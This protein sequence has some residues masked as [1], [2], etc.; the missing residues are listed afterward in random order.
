MSET[1][2]I[3]VIGGGIIGS[4][5]AYYLAKL[6]GISTRIVICDRGPIAGATS[7]SCMGHL[8]VT[9]DNAQEYALTKT[10]VD[11]WR[12]LHEDLG[13]FDYN[14]TGALYL[15]ETDEDQE[16]I[17]VLH[18]QFADNGDQADVLDQKQVRE[19]EPGLADDIPGALYYSGDGVVLP[20]LAAGAMLRG[21]QAR[22]PNV[23]VR[24]N[25]AVKG[26]ERDGDGISA[27]VTEHSVIATKTVVNACGIWTPDIG[28][29]LGQSRIPIYPRAGNLA[30]TGHH[31]SPIRT[32]LLEINYLR[33]AHATS[34]VDPTKT[35]ADSGGHA[36]NMQPQTNG[37]C[38]I[39]S[40]R[41]FRGRNKEVNRDLLRRSL[42]RA[43]RYV[44]GIAQAPIVRTWVGLRPYSIDNHPLIGPWDPVP[45]FWI[46]AGH[47]GLGI[48]MAP[49]T[50]LLIAQQIA[51]MTPSVNVAPYLPAR[52]VS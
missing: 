25:C 13:G 42:Q 30:I 20:M 36:V 49:V 37:G 16:M 39:G 6:L 41:Q 31:V 4:S 51:G 44:P 1:A 10:S 26:I 34:D 12:G 50:G 38:L 17:P 11:L 45:G 48:S 52:F 28:D 27:V 47:E 43:Q 33:F 23:I 19:I 15:A 2:D 8:M 35:D 9:P 18:K 46:A 32:Q 7:A 24:A 3:V 29:M 21:A 22:N 40:T 5:V 14:P